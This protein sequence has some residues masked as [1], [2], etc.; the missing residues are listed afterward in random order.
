MH[1]SVTHN[2]TRTLT[3]IKG[4]AGGDFYYIVNYEDSVLA[5]L[6]VELEKAPSSL[7]KATDRTSLIYDVFSLA[8]LVLSEYFV[9]GTSY[10]GD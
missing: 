7:S 5:Q 6:K 1:I 8:S 4:N 3:W 9:V 10:K 2:V